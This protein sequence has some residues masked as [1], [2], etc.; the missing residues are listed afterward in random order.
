[1]RQSIAALI[2]FAVGIP[3]IAVAE[4]FNEWHTQC[5]S[6]C[7]TF[8]LQEVYKW[9]DSEPFLIL[10]EVTS[11]EGMEVSA[12]VSREEYEKYYTL[13]PSTEFRRSGKQ[14]V[15]ARQFF[16]DS[17]ATIS[18]DG[19]QLQTAQPKDGGH[20]VGELQAATLNAFREGHKAEVSGDFCAAPGCA[21]QSI[22]FSLIGF[23]A[24]Y[25]ARTSNTAPDTGS[26]SDSSRD[27]VAAVADALVGNRYGIQGQHLRAKANP[28]GRGIFV[29]VPEVEIADYERLFV[30]FVKGGQPV[31]LNGPSIS[32][33]K[34]AKRPLEMGYKF[35]E[36]TGL[37]SD[38]VTQ[39]G[40][41]TV[42]RDR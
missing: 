36:A 6:G 16:S 12:L 23:S 10:L 30:W 7:Q 39:R 4:K 1:M 29:Y 3:G 9:E 11:G 24:A 20:M 27:P 37:S 41:D 18:V 14:F 25:A 8:T 35:W 31:A 21:K 33:T 28:L 38:N 32:V 22:T 17:P 42:Y 2:L 34:N 5:D 40:L 15:G 26:A 13:D 19:Q